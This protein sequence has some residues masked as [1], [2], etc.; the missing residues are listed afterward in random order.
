MTAHLAGPWPALPYA[1]W[2]DTLATL[3]M[4]MQILGKVRV[5]LSPPEPEWAHVALYL[6]ARG[7]TT[8]VVPSASGLFEVDADF[9]DHQ[10]VVHTAWGEA[11]AVPLSARPVADFFAEFTDAL[12]SVGIDVELSTMPQEVPDPIPFPDDGVHH[13][14]DPEHAH[15]FWYIL[16]LMQPVFAEYRAAFHGRVTP[17]QFFWGGMDLAITR[18]SGRPCDPPPNADFLLRATYDAEQISAGWWPGNDAFPE[19]AF[20]AYSYPKA[21]GIEQVGL[22]PEAA[23]WNTDLGEHLLRYDDVRTAASPAEEIRA[24]FDSFYAA[25]AMRCEWDG[26]LV[27]AS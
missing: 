7:L 12:Q 11:R 13:T 15:H 26:S 20:Y 3:H 23:S 19:P 21:D 18:F 9:F 6:T 25:A 16:T 5:A 10:V 1:E 8:G 22:R 17:V 24:F 27:P 4:E 14:Y 2:N